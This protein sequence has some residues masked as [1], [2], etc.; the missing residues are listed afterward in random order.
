MVSYRRL[1]LMEREELSRMLAAEHSLRAT[2]R[3]L[4]RARCRVNSPATAPAPLPI[5]PSRP[6][7]RPNGGL[8]AHG[9]LASSRSIPGSAGPYWHC[10]PS[11]GRP[12]RLPTGC[13]SGILKT[14]PCGSRTK[15]SIP[16]YMCCRAVRSS[17]SWPAICGAAT[18]SVGPTRS[19]AR[20]GRFRTL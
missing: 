5:E 3:A 19:A 14:R 1:T 15:R 11:A 20:R 4:Q 7:S 9:S 17:T 12:N 16:L 6:T 13:S 18:A 8:I 2:A 10:W